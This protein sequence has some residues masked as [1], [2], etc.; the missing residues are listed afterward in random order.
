MVEWDEQIKAHLFW[1]WKEDEGLL[2]RGREGMLV[3]TDRRLAF[4]SKTEMAYRAHDAHSHRQLNRF[5][6][7]E[8]VFRPAEGYSTK[9]LEKDLDKSPDNFEV[10]FRQIMDV[11]SEEKRWGTL[12]KVKLN[13]GDT[14]KT[15]KF[16]IVK[17]WVTYPAKDPLEFQRMDWAPLIN[18]VK[19]AA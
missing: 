16:S 3:I 17:G 10:P 8:N 7:G 19:T 4:I 1:I 18:L 15:V 12:L 11:T 13:L 5:K 2:K 9:D 6:E 14:T